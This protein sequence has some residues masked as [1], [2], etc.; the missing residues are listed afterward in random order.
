MQVQW[1]LRSLHEFLEA[2]DEFIIDRFR[3]RLSGLLLTVETEEEGDDELLSAART[4]A[5]QY[6]AALRKYVPGLMNLI[7]LEEFA[8][9]PA[10]AITIHGTTRA[11]RKRLDDAV[12]RARNEMLASDDPCLRQ[13]YDYI[14]QA[15]EDE[16]NCLFHLYKF[17]ETLE[18]VFGGEAKMICA[19][20]KMDS[21]SNIKK[22]VKGLKKLAN[23]PLHDARHAPKVTG[24][25]KRLSA[26]DRTDAMRS[27]YEILH[28]YERHVRLTK[29]RKKA[30]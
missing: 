28:V 26:E 19:L 14:G 18:D 1:I 27:A 5:E 20:E 17:V 4:L 29:G 16:S 11:E 21:I 15:Y 24:E 25:V 7:T 6:V 2:S 22:L 8:S 3:L 30:A 23:A 12:R 10:R 9:L 13:C